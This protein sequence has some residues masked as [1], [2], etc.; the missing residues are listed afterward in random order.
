MEPLAPLLGG[1]IKIRVYWL[2]CTKFNSGQLLF[3]TFFDVIGNFCSIPPWSELFFSFWCIIFLSKKANF[4]SPLASILGEIEIR[5][6]W[7][8]CR[9]FYFV[10]FLF[11]AF[12]NIIGIFCSI[13]SKKSE[14][15]I[16]D[17]SLRFKK[18][19]IFFRL[20]D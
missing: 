19:I 20:I 4:W 10:Q 18:S 11:D 15:K 7:R 8:F 17:Y 14:T 9:Q 2:I 12:F 5:L 13:L 6:Y 3:E 1:G 16:I